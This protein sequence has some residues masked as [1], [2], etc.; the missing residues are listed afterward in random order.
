MIRPSSD[1]DPYFRSVLER[2]L[3][4]SAIK[5]AASGGGRDL[6]CYCSIYFFPSSEAGSCRLQA[7]CSIEHR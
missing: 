5:V 6:F 3:F 2:T 7:C 1:L 4:H